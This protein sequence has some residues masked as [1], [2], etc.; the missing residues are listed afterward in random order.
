MRTPNATTAPFYDVD[1]V[2]GRA[3]QVFFVD[4]EVARALG[5]LPGWFWWECYPGCLPEGDAFGPFPTSY[6][7]Y[8]DALTSVA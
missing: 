5:S 3:I 1:W 2:N 8:R 6:R 4:H 7:A